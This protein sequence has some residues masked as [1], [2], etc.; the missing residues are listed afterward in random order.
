MFW[1]HVLKNTTV[2]FRGEDYLDIDELQRM[3][4]FQSM[5]ERIKGSKGLVRT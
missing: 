5:P 1:I 4:L 3:P 2:S